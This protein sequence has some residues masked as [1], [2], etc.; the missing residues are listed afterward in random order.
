ML[1]LKIF[2]GAVFVV[3]VLDVVLVFYI[4]GAYLLSSWMERKRR[5]RKK[6]DPE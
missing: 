3:L 2:I 6:E 1:A 4:G 5:L